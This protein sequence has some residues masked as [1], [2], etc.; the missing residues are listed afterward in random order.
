VFGYVIE[1][2]YEWA[3]DDNKATTATAGTIFAFDLGKYKS[4]ACAYRSADDHRF[5]TL[6]TS[7]A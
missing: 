1:G 7:R 5:T 3:I 2:E 6:P 4:V